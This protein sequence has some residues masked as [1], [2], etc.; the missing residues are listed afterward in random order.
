MRSI[1]A[2]FTVVAGL[3]MIVSLAAGWINHWSNGAL[4]KALSLNTVLA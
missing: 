4:S 3:L 2:K 1:R